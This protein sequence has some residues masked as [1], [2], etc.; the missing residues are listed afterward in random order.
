[1]TVDSGIREIGLK[2]P[3]KEAL[4]RAA[5]ALPA[6]IYD[7]SFDARAEVM[8]TV[9]ASILPILRG[10]SVGEALEQV[11]NGSLLSVIAR[12]MP[13][14]P[15]LPAPPLDGGRPVGKETFVSEGLAL[16]MA[17]IL[18]EPTILLGEK[19][20]ALVHQ[21]TPVEGRENTQSNEGAVPLKLHQD[22]APNPTM[23]GL[24]YDHFMPEQLILTGIIKGRGTETQL[25]SVDEA[26]QRLSARSQ[27]VLRQ[28]RF[29]TNPPDSFV[30]NYGDA[31]AYPPHHAILSDFEGHVEMAFDT[32]SHVRPVDPQDDE[33]KAAMAELETA[34][35]AVSVSVGI[36]PG[37]TVV[38][39]NRRMA[40][41][42]G[43][44]TVN[45]YEDPKRRWLQR[46]HVKDPLRVARSTMGRP[47]G[48][49]VAPGLIG[50]ASGETHPR[51]REL[52]LRA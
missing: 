44:V 1:M 5:L 38:F 52:G 15:S 30:K 40:H 25:A 37:V 2:G 18:G 36:E 39:N 51:L 27:A 14:D 31:F 33:A 46:I 48:L 4:Q 26:L 13:T 21:I 34:L 3:E 12:D 49:Q 35:A 9:R 50:V 28:K 10:T 32:S 17:Q 19:D 8:S 24:R 11:R 20:E 45:S 7:E 41:G 47:W 23:P 43:A 29:I 16:A 6:G 22:L 42:R